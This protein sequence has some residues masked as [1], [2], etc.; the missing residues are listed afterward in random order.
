LALVRVTLLAFPLHPITPRSG[1][2]GDKR[3]RNIENNQ[4]WERRGDQEVE[5]K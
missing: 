2:R 5:M 4:G 3:K 1:E